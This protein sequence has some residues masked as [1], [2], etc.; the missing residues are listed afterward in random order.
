MQIIETISDFNTFLKDYETQSSI[1]VPVFCDSRLHPAQNRLCLLGV[2]GIK[3][4]K[5]FILPFNHP[6]ATNLPYK[7]I[8]ELSKGLEIW[9]PDKKV[10]GFLPIEDQGHIEDVQA[11]DYVV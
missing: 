2:Y 3:S 1:L 9:T 6:E 4:K 10:L 5:L 8:K 7:V 11:L